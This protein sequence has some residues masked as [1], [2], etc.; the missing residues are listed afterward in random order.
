MVQ[1]EDRHACSHESNHSILVKRIPFAED[2]E[3]EE[4]NR[5]ELA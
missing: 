4:H 3:V 1:G 2:S 5:K